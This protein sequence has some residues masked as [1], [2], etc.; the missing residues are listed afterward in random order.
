M[1]SGPRC[2]TSFTGSSHF[3]PMHRAR[4]AQ[5]AGLPRAATPA[6]IANVI[7]FLASDEAAYVNGAVV[8]TDGGWSSF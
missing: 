7:T 3:R 1:D 5:L 4:V 2:A 6:E 8:T